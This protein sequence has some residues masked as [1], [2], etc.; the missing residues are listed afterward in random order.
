MVYATAS[1]TRREGAA[2][3]RAVMIS[4]DTNILAHDAI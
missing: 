4:F 2:G 3:A 1:V